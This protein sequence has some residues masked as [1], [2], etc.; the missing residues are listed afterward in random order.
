M[1]NKLHHCRVSHYIVMCAKFEYNNTKIY[2]DRIL[3]EST[4][5]YILLF[6]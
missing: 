2:S 3:S 4:F 1:L 6:K 5:Y